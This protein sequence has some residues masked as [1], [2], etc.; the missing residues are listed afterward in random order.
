MNTQ[1]LSTL[2]GDKLNVGEQATNT[3]FLPCQVLHLLDSNSH[4]Y[5]ARTICKH[6]STMFSLLSGQLIISLSD[7]ISVM[8]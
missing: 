7:L 3:S 6:Y 2:P 4:R 8:L 5:P 1:V